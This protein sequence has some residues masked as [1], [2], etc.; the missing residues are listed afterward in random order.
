MSIGAR[1]AIV[2]LMISHSSYPHRDLVDEPHLIFCVLETSRPSRLAA[3]HGETRLNYG[4][5]IEPEDEPAGSNL[6]RLHLV[7]R[8]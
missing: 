3:C 2:G 5:A 7:I 4:L 8:S 1:S 6:T